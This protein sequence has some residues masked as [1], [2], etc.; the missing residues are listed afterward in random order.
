MNDP[1]IWWYVTRS[2]AVLAW[3]LLTVSVMWGILLS[4]RVARRIDNPS[5]LQDLH[6]YVSGVA[7]IMVLIH[8]GSLMLDGYLHLSV[9]E[10]FVP[11][12]SHY[13]ALAVALGVLSVYLMVAIW[14]SSLIKDRIPRGVWKGI[15]YASYVVVLLVAFHAGWTGTDVTELWYRVVA[16]VLIGLTAISLIVRV[17]VGRPKP[18]ARPATAALPIVE[19][20]V[21]P[22]GARR[23][24]VSGRTQ[25][26]ES[27]TQF[28]LRAVDGATLPEW[29]PGDHISLR[30]PNGLARQYSLCGDPANADVWS[31]AVKRSP[32]SAGGSSWLHEQLWLGDEIDVHGPANRF[33]LVPAHEYLF[34]AGGIGITPIWSMIQS[35]PAHRDWQLIFLGSTRADMAFVDDLV[36]LYPDRVTIWESNE[37]GKRFDLTGLAVRDRAEVYACGPEP[38]LTDLQRV[39]APERLHFERFEGVDQAP[40]AESKPFEVD[41]RRSAKIVAVTADQTML[42]AL[43]SAGIGVLASCREGICGSCEVRVVSGQPDH[44]DQVL[45]DETKVKLKVM[46]PC[47]SR[48]TSDRLVIDA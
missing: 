44:R 7:I 28:D 34:V 20:A 29:Q 35:L 12:A 14:L 39:I 18:V 26:A 11:F 22:H 27:I 46:Y 6:R 36:R 3:V 9:T 4:T 37:R 31:I 13:R 19:G 41:C 43:E 2:S 25:V 45:D 47:V 32:Q 21:E 42:Q 1:H 24:V 10:L 48:A 16:G 30:L 38:M 15:H 23:M 17:T 5:W 8:M 40:P 33:K